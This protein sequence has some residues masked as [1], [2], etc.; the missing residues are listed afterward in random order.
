MKERILI[1]VLSS[2]LG[3]FIFFLVAS[4]LGV[5]EKILTDSN[6]HELARKVVDEDKYRNVILE[7]MVKSGKFRG[8]K[9]ELGPQGVQGVPGPGCATI[10]VVSR[11][12][13]IYYGVPRPQGR[14]Y[15]ASKEITVSYTIEVPV[16]EGARIIGAWYEPHGNIHSLHK[17][18]VIRIARIPNDNNHIRL[19]L[20]G[21]SAGSMKIGINVLYQIP[22]G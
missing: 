22:F 2:I 18:D 9:G 8:N 3:A 12:V 10:G 11:D 16:P 1:S 7:Q 19:S 4:S 20:N 21:D 15:L 13:G 14:Y 5:F 6:L 17:F